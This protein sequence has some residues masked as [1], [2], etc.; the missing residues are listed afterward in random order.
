MTI[1]L[2]VLGAALILVTLRDIF[3][4]LFNPTS[5][6]AVSNRMIRTVW[7]ASRTIARRW[8]RMLSIAGPLAMLTV[9]ALWTVILILGWALILWPRLPGD[10][11]LSTGL[12]PAD[13]SGFWDAVYLSTVSLA[14]LGYGDMTPISTDLRLV[15]PLEALVG[16]GLFTASI[17]W[18]LS[19][20]PVLARRRNLAR[21]VTLLEE[22]GGWDDLLAAKDGS[23]ALNGILS[24]LTRQLVF[25]RNDYL[26]FPITYYFQQRDREAALDVA[27]P[28]LVVLSE[29][30][31]RHPSTSIRFQADLLHDAIRDITTY[32]GESFLDLEDAAMEDIYIAFEKDHLREVDAAPHRAGNVLER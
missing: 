24:G 17:S 1:F 16:F 12:P 7:R 26:Q 8:P 6:G 21:E 11:L 3:H 25:A 15:A 31:R 18:I 27:L 10:F 13:N 20:Y 22:S 5:S 4:T 23:D 14:T 2:T 9:I 19:V 32:L 28:H 30:A 29:S